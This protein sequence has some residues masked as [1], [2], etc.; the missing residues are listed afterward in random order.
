M[1]EKIV[2]WDVKNQNKP[3]KSR[4]Q[5]S[6]LLPASENAA[7]HWLSHDSMGKGFQD[8]SCIPVFRIL[9]CQIR[10]LIIDFLIS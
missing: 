8:Y 2:D 1:T 6:L 3:K 5:F 4:R 9:K 10:E 7:V